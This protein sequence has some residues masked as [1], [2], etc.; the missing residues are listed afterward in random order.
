MVQMDRFHIERMAWASLH[1]QTREPRRQPM[2]KRIAHVA[3]LTLLLGIVFVPSLHASPRFSFS[4]RIGPSAAIA[5]YGVA[6]RAPSG[7]VWQPGY[8]GQTPFGARSVEGAWSPAPNAR[9]TWG[10]DQW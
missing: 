2:R 6:P 5:P 10:G 4:L 1:I 9:G 8:Y 7:Y 3:G